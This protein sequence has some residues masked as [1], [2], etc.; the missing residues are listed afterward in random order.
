MLFCKI[1]EAGKWKTNK[2]T[3]QD[4]SSA[5]SSLGSSCSPSP[6]QSEHREPGLLNA[7]ASK[8]RWWRAGKDG[9][10]LRGWE[11]RIKLWPTERR[12]S[13]RIARQID[14]DSTESHREPPKVYGEWNGRYF[15]LKWATSV[16][17]TQLVSAGKPNCHA[18][19]T[20]TKLAKL[21]TE[22]VS[23]CFLVELALCH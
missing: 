2:L 19:L 11:V 1:T 20:A 4:Q 18:Q 7:P 5:V 16:G 10:A 9:G 15:Q 13:H 12:Q 23:A 22:R 17:L 3:S 14:R 21:L 8:G 6:G